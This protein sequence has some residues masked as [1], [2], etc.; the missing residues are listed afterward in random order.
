MNRYAGIAASPTAAAPA[1]ARTAATSKN[2]PPAA[3][4]LTEAEYRAEYGHV[5]S[6]LRRIAILAGSVFAFLI[7]LSVIIH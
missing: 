4:I 3:K 7:I 1:D 6:D 5:S 2:A